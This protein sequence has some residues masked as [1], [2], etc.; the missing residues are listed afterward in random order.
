MEPIGIPFLLAT[1]ASTQVNKTRL[2]ESV[3][4]AVV[5][6]GLIA[7]AGYYV[8]FPVLQE[9]VAQMRREGLETRQLIRDIQSDLQAM[10]LR[11]DQTE[12]ELRNKIAELQVQIAKQR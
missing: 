1:G 8:A 11:R 4:T 2:I 12:V 10:S 7:M 5:S 3:I 6:G 9:Q